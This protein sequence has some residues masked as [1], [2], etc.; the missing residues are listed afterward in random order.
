MCVSAGAKGKAEGQEVREQALLGLAVGAGEEDGGVGAGELEEGLAAGAAGLA[1]GAVE[2]GYS[3]SVDADCGAV[4]GHGRGYGGLF[5]AGGKAEGGVFHVAAGDDG[6]GLGE[7]EGGANAEA[8]VGGVGVLSHSVGG[9]KERG[10][11]D[12]GEEA[13][14]VVEATRVCGR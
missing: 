4:P 9:F 13:H 5:G 3:D 6:V 14:A 2:V 8:A 12:V 11:F 7:E 10:A 1:R